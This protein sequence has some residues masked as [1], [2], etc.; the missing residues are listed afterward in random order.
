MSG[1]ERKDGHRRAPGE[2][3]MRRQRTV[4]VGCRA[5]ARRVQCEGVTMP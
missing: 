2:E 5:E 4:E 3:E 1:E